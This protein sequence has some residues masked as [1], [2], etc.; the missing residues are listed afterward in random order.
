MVW[1]W[2]RC[3]KI[4]TTQIQITILISRFSTGSRV[5]CRPSTGCS[6]TVVYLRL[7]SCHFTTF[8]ARRL[9][10]YSSTG[11]EAGRAVPLSRPD[12]NLG[13]VVAQIRDASVLPVGRASKSLGRGELDGVLRRRAAGGYTSDDARTDDALLVSLIAAVPF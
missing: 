5:H 2:G 13:V 9:S 7:A 10:C 4:G 6:S 11:A 1:P 8:D 3:C 12:I